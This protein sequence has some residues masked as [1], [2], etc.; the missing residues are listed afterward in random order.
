MTSCW[1]FDLPMFA[2]KANELL[3]SKVQQCTLSSIY[4]LFFYQFDLPKQRMFELND[5]SF[6]GSISLELS[7]KSL[8]RLY[9]K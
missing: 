8:G 2:F 6:P 1:L 3:F 9:Y 7:S 5:K 4:L